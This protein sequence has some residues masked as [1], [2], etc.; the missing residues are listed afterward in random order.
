[1]MKWTANF[2]SRGDCIDGIRIATEDSNETVAIM[3]WR[4]GQRDKAIE[5]ARLIITAVNA[6]S[7]SID[8]TITVISER[9]L[10]G[11]ILAKEGIDINK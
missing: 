9:E 4:P 11:I 1:M 3:S 7:G 5:T 6:Y 10:F 2:Y 8:E